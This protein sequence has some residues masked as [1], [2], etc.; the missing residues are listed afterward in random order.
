MPS[1]DGR[2]S[3]TPF[4]VHVYSGL[5][6]ASGAQIIVTVPPIAALWLG[7]RGCF[8]NDG[9]NAAKEKKPC[10]ID[11]SGESRNLRIIEDLT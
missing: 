3:G 10:V 9:L 7:F 8:A 5:G 6:A 2:L 1:S 4:L 11:S